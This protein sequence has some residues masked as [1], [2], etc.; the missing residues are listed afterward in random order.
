MNKKLILFLSFIFP[1]VIFLTLTFYFFPRN[2]ANNNNS[3]ESL[4]QEEE[5]EEED[6]NNEKDK[7]E[8]NNKD[9]NKENL[10]NSQENK[11]SKEEIEESIKIS[12]YFS[13]LIVIFFCVY[14]LHGYIEIEKTWSNWKSFYKFS[15]SF[16][17][18]LFKIIKIEFFLPLGIISYI[19]GFTELKFQIIYERKKNIKIES[20]LKKNYKLNLFYSISSFIFTIFI[21]IFLLSLISLP[22]LVIANGLKNFKKRFRWRYLFISPFLFFRQGNILMK[23]MIILILIFIIY[24]SV[25]LSF[26]KEIF[27]KFILAHYFIKYLNSFNK[28]S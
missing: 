25:G 7:E 26:K 10:N 18:N 5:N 4:I 23:I 20:F 24:F 17:K 9:E 16:F 28:K 12:N 8:L 1:L 13:I 6:E 15:N 11:E 22:F 19:H 14:I 21:F 27:I 3:Q 2:K